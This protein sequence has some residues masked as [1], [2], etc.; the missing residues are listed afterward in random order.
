MV[1]LGSRG[2]PERLPKFS[3]FF[4]LIFLFLSL[5][6]IVVVVVVVVF[7]GRGAFKPVKGL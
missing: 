7:E 1:A 6:M 2:A 4:N 3:L 5:F